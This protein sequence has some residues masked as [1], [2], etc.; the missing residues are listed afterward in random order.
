MPTLRK[1]SQINN[2]PLYLKELEKLE[3]TWSKDN[4]RYKITKIRTEINE[5]EARKNIGK[6]RKNKNFLKKDKQN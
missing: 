1:N 3:Q 2:L 4:R 5:T 6:I